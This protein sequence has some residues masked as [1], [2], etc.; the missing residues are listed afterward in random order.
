MGVEY[1]NS[2]RDSSEGF[3]YQNEFQNLPNLNP[4]SNS[5]VY[6]GKSLFDEQ[7]FDARK[8]Y[9]NDHTEE[10]SNESSEIKEPK[11][12]KESSNNTTSSVQKE[13]NNKLKQLFTTTN[14]QK[15]EEEKKFIGKKTGRK[16]KN[17]S[18]NQKPNKKQF[19]RKYDMD[20]IMIKNQVI[21]M[22]EKFLPV[23]HKIKKLA[24]FDNFHSLKEK[25]IGDIVK[26]N[27]SNKYKKFDLNHNEILYEK[28]IKENPV[29]KKF[30]EQ[31][32]ITF[33]QKFYYKGEKSINLEEYGFNGILTLPDNVKTHQDKIKSFKEPKY[34]ETYENYVRDLYFN[35]KIKINFQ[36][37]KENN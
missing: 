32:Y 23:A 30:L 13:P 24:T 14:I 2:P 37:T 26:S 16:P 15:K 27:R 34:A 7:D 6:E 12:T 5:N 31:N 1:N 4:F 21:K 17:E 33:F 25:S 10:K 8:I 11:E 28:I 9:Y 29:L 22:N 35:N 18:V 36:A 20:D 19:S 3:F